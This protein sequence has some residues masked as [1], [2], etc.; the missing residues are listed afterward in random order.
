MPIAASVLKGFVFMA[1]ALWAGSRSL[2][3]NSMPTIALRARTPTLDIAYGQTGPADGQAVLLLHGFP[4]D[5]RQY[6]DVLEKD[7]TPQRSRY[8]ALST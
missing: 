4:Y 5:V 1:T 6:D 8:F 7:R 3:R 2:H